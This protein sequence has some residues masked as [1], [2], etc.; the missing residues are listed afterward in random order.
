VRLRGRSPRGEHPIGHAPH[1]RRNITF[2]AALRQGEM[3]S[4]FRA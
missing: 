2:V 1:E 3:T 4:A